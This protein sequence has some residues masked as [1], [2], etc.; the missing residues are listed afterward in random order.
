MGLTAPRIEL[1]VRA[2]CAACGRAREDLA[3]ICGPLDV[4][5][6]E[7]DVDE[8]AAAGDGEPRAEYGDRL[9]VVLLDGEEHSYWE[10]DAPRLLADLRSRAK[11]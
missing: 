4:P 5:V 2:G 11:A 1:L 7:V 6:T 3:R 8:A 10:V 9:P